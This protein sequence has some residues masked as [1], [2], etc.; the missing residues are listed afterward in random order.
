[1]RRFRW[2][3]CFLLGLALASPAHAQP[4][5]VPERLRVLIE[6]D[7]GGDPDDEQSLVRFLLYAS[8]WDVE[9]IICTLPRARDKENL[10]PERTGLGIVRRQLKAYGECY[11]NLVKHDRR[12]PTIEYLWQRTF[13][14]YGGDAGVKLVL[15]AADA[16]DPRAADTHSDFEMTTA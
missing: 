14:G 2:F 12:F 9:G 11:P 16:P 10:N 8:E 5:E 13:A 7:A 3:S 6:T 1:M 15:D 4:A